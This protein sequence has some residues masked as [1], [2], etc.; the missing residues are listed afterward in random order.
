MARHR[1]MAELKEMRRDPDPDITLEMEGETLEKWNAVINAPQGCPYEG[2]VFRLRLD[3]PANYPLSPPTVTF[4]TK[5]F[6]PNVKYDTG[7]LCLDILK[8]DWSPAWTLRFVCRAVV[9]LLADPNAD[10]PLNCD[11]GNLLR[12]G[13]IRGFRSLARMYTIDYAIPEGRNK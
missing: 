9:A 12:S 5:C 11:A 2:G 4:I 10:S 3:C 6:H 8:T 7:E 1:L 13:D